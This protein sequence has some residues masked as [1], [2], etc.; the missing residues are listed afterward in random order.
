[1]LNE[2]LVSVIV[3]TYNRSKILLDTIN[4]ILN[5]SWINIEI[6]VIDDCSKDDTKNIIGEINSDIIRYKK[7]DRNKGCAYARKVG[8]EISKGEY[9]AF[10]DDDDRW[11]YNYLKNQME[12]FEKNPIFN[13]VISNYV[14]KKKGDVFYNM[15]PFVDNFKYMIHKVPGPFFQCCLFKKEIL[16]NPHKLFD[17]KSIPSEDWD[18]FI[19]LSNRKLNIGHSSKIGF[20]WIYNSS[21]QSSNLNSEIGAL[22][23]I[24]LK[25]QTS[26]IR[27][28]GKVILSDHYRRIAR[29]FEKIYNFNFARHYY[30]KAFLCAPYHWKN[31]LYFIILLC[32]TQLG[33]ALI[34]HLRN[35]R[36]MK[37]E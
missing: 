7:L 27:V 19:N 11:D 9:I 35:I 14:I 5:Q 22:Q 31:F 30:K 12:V 15:K 37:N 10:L 2:P 21:G 36:N 4:S 33:F 25:H 23:H 16:S 8:V 29:L 1:M 24:I 28:C 20:Y 3:P 32:N 34:K 26:I 18:F 6:I 17:F 13:L